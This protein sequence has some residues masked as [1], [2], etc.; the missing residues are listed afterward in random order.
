MLREPNT[1]EMPERAT[2]AGIPGVWAGGRFYPLVA[3][4]APDGD[5]EGGNNG[6]DGASGSDGAGGGQGGQQAGKD[7]TPFDAERAQ[8]TIERQ[9][10]EL[11]AAKAQAAEA[12]ALRAKVAEFENAGKSEIERKDAEI[13]QAREKT[14][15]AEQRAAELEGRYK[16]A[17]IR[18]A[19]EREAVKAGAIDADA[20]FALID[21]STLQVGDDDAV[22]GADKAVEAFAKARPHLFKATDTGA[23]NGGYKP[24]KPTPPSGG[25]PAAE[26]DKQARDQSSAHW[27]SRF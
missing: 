1:G 19:V 2:L 23:G 8:R 27:R 16:T 5:G 15:A 17:L 12:E 22:M 26:I 3:G 7:G 4:G 13:A 14:T 6:G 21:R 9:R 18:Q 11:K 24:V 25:P 10:E 20:V